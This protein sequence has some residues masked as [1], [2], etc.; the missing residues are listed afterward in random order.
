[1]GFFDTIL[2]TDS[3][4][5]KEANNMRVVKEAKERKNEILDAALELFVT[6]GYDG[7]STNDILEKVNI[8][9]G[10][11][12]YHFKSKEDIMDALIGRINDTMIA[13]ATIIALNKKVPFYERIVKVI[14]SLHISEDN[15]KEI[16]EHIHKPQ[17]ALMHQ[18]IQSMIVSGITPILSDLITEGI[19]EGVFQ[20]PYP[21]ECMEMIM[22]YANTVFDQNMDQLTE[23]ERM[24]KIYAFVFHLERMLGAEEGSL[25]YVMQTFKA[26]EGENDE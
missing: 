5:R 20:T 21:Y 1:M 13:N 11:L 6:K 25:K 15:S 9:R 2:P 10:T 16:M 7:T 12:Y 24:R 22:I 14:M 26:D 3:R 8:A 4:Y 23:D 19:K 18:K 17:N